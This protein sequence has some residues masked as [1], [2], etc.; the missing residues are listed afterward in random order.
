MKDTKKILFATDFSET[1]ANAREMAVSMRDKYD[2][3]LHIIHVFDPAAFEMPAPYFFMPGADTWLR[4]RL[5][6]MRTRGNRALNEL[7]AAVGNCETHFIEGRPGRTIVEFAADNDID[8]IIMGTHG[9]R[10]LDRMLL[11][12][13]A[14]YVI[15]HTDA[16]VLT[17]KSPNPKS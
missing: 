9:H 12:S 4:D 3:E 11:G 14:E 1:S 8:M 16:A 7:T 2:A 15:R 13:V 17:L 5:E 10:G 6:G